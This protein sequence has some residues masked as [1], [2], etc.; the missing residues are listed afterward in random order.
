MPGFTSRDDLI[1]EITVNGKADLWN[2][3]KISPAASETGGVWHSLWRGVGNPG[4][5]ANPATTPGTVYD[6]DPASIVAGSIFFPDR[7][8]DEKYLLSFG[9][10][11]AAACTLMLYDRLAGVSGISGSSTGAKTVNSGALSRYSGAAAVNNEAWIEVSTASTATAGV[12]NLNSYTSA[13]GTTGL[14][15]GS[16]TLPAA[17]TNIDTLVQLPLAANEQGIRSI[18]AGI[19]IGTASTSL[20]FNALII[21]PLVRLPLAAGVWNEVSLL[22]DTFGLPRIFDNACLGLAVVGTASITPTV[23]GTINCAYG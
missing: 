11:C 3:Y 14:S 23:W 18:E 1:N 22:D 15:G 12:M 13:D 7:S 20:V 21:R 5:G 6:S 9:A 17:A 2:F 4:A 8:T 16:V 19:N 10:I